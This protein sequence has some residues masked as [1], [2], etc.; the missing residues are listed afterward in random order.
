MALINYAISSC[1]E[2]IE[3]GVDCRQ[4][5]L[6]LAGYL[7]VCSYSAEALCAAGWE[8]AAWLCGWGLQKSL[9]I[10]LPEGL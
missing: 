8:L 5:G 10:L 7:W 4:G 3:A 9:K 1:S 6:G 2:D